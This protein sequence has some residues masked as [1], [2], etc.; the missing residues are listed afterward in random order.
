MKVIQ[1]SEVIPKLAGLLDVKY[2]NITLIPSDFVENYFYK[3]FGS[4]YSINSDSSGFLSDFN[5]YNYTKSEDLNR[6][7]EA[8]YSNYNP[9]ENYN[10]KEK[11]TQTFGEQNET[12]IDGERQ[13]SNTIGNERSTSTDSVT[14]FDS[15]DFSE[16][17]K[18]ITENNART[19]NSIKGIQTNR[20]NSNEYTNTII[21][22]KSGNLG[23]TTSQQMIESEIDMRLKNNIKEKYLD[24]FISEWC[25]LVD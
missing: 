23:V 1:I 19:D 22:E 24:M 2:N 16:T 10:G 11:V 20:K 3:K 21:T 5:Y 25:Y 7:L 18:N 13:D 8:Y 14:S 6:M 15:T 4:W 12:Y 9:L 17:G